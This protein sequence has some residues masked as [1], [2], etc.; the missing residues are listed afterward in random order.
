MNAGEEA[1]RDDCV[2]IEQK[3][4]NAP[5]KKRHLGHPAFRAPRFRELNVGHLGGRPTQSWATR[6]VVV[7]P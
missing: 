3:S 7:I 1:R 6:R 2:S 4:Q 5:V